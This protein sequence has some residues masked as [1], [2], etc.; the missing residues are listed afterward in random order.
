MESKKIDW[1]KLSE[2]GIIYKINKEVLHPIGL[3]L[4][5]DPETGVSGGCYVE[6]EP[7]EYSTDRIEY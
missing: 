5:R 1:N 6:N 3:S 4:Y 2:L 7:W